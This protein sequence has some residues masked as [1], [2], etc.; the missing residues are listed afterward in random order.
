MVERLQIKIEFDSIEDRLLLRISEGKGR[1]C[2]E[3][4]L[5]LTRRFVGIFIK[6]IDKLIEDILLSDMQLSLEALE[7]MKKFQ[8]EAA[9]AKADFLT[10]YGGDAKN[11]ALIGAPPLLVSSL[12]IKEKTKGRYVFSL[13]TTKNEGVHLTASMDLIHSLRKMLVDSAR[14]AEWLQPVIRGIGQE[15]KTTA[16]VRFAS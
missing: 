5:W 4:R 1:D 6:T 10:S 12:K 8:Q 15:E 14:N 13:L 9:L 7:A 16:H 11:C 2:L 3:Y